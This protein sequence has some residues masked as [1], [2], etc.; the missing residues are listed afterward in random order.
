MQYDFRKNQARKTQPLCNSSHNMQS[1]HRIKAR[2]G[3]ANLGL[4]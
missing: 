2:L 1:S 3:I 4:E